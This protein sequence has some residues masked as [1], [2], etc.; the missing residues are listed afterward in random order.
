LGGYELADG[1][2]VRFS[3][4]YHSNFPELHADFMTQLTEDFGILWGWGTGNKVKSTPSI[5]VF[6]WGLSLKLTQAKTPFELLP[7]RWTPG[8]ANLACFS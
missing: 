7:L 1:T 8:Q 2:Q 4:W 6:A 3:N 5:P